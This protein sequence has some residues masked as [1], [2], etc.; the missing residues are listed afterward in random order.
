MITES[1]NEMQLL[2]SSYSE[3]A[4][5]CYELLRT[6]IPYQYNILGGGG[7]IPRK[8]TIKKVK[9]SFHGAGCYFEFND[10]S[11]ID[12]DFGPKNRYDG[13]DCDRLRSFYESMK[14]EVLFPALKDKTIFKIEFQK[15]IVRNIIFCPGWSPAHHLYYL[16]EGNI[17]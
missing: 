6:K 17:G 10:K 13:F 11:F 8:G 1:Q 4:K 15:L 12:V 9:Y 2:I 7:I 5:F 14:K 3:K 16:C